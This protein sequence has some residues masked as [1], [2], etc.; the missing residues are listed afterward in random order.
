[1]SYLLRLLIPEGLVKEAKVLGATLPTADGE[2]GILPGHADYL[3]LIGKGTLTLSK[4]DGEKEKF[5]IS[6]GF[7]RVEK[8]ICEVLAD[9]VY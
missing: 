4:E 6:G 8:G 7:C 9:S 1:M 3:A 2:I 5:Q